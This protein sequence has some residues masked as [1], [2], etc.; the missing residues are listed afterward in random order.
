MTKN[1][2]NSSAIA[3]EDQT[4]IQIR[5][6]VPYVLGLV[7]KWPVKAALASGEISAVCACD[8]FVFIAQEHSSGNTSLS[9]V[10]L[11]DM[12]LQS[13][14]QLSHAVCGMW[15]NCDGT[16][17]AIVN[18][19]VGFMWIKSNCHQGGYPKSQNNELFYALPWISMPRMQGN[20]EVLSAV[21]E[22]TVGTASR[23]DVWDALW[24]SDDPSSLAIMEKSKMLILHET[25]IEDPL[26]TNHFL[27]AF[28]NLEV[29]MLDVVLLQAKL[30]VS[31]C[32]SGRMLRLDMVNLFHA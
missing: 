20:M 12:Q 4:V 32:M 7:D 23:T 30:A 21:D 8:R 29:L 19:Q 25:E 9:R 28:G 6:G 26:R 13:T 5:D 3:F 27:L 10:S 16:R 15:L 31:I 2:P 18:Q 17:V 1:D 24:A 14:H 22:T 11:P